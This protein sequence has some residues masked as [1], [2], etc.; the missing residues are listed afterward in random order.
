MS[1]IY[2]IWTPIKDDAGYV[3]IESL[4]DDKGGLS[5]LLREHGSDRF[6]KFLFKDRL[7]Y[8]CRDESDLEGDASRSEGLG[9]G[10]LYV[11]KDSELLARFTKDSVR[12]YEGIMHFAFVTDADC[13]DVLALAHPSVEYL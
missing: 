9:R 4:V 11:V 6:L 5:V 1:Q 3:S 7:M 8:Q 2:Q 12:Y 10:C 13:I